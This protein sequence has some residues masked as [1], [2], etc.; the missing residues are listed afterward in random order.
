MYFEICL[1]ILTFSVVDLD[2]TNGINVTSST[3][4]IC[5][6][7]IGK[8]LTHVSYA[9]VRI[10]VN[11]KSSL[12]ENEKVFMASKDLQSKL[13]IHLTNCQAKHLN[14][15]DETLPDFI[16]LCDK[17]VKLPLY[18]YMPWKNSQ[19]SKLIKS[20]LNAMSHICEESK[21]RINEIQE[22]S[23]KTVFRQP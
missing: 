18:I 8:L 4:Q 11:L 19:I 1:L 6:T 12:D 17:N 10:K 2:P 9:T 15:S 23:L 20:L 5:F 16:K 7:K 3:S 21:Q 13:R 14:E 22:I